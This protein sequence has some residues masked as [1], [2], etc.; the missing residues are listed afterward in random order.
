M[1]RRV[2]ILMVAVFA[3]F[4][5]AKKS[6]AWQETHRLSLSWA[7][8]LVGE[9]NDMCLGSNSLYVAED[10][11][12]FSIINLTD[13]TRKWYTSLKAMDGSTTALIKIRKIAVVEP[14]NRL[15]INE[16]DGTDLIRIIDT[17]D[18]DTLKDTIPITGATADIKDMKFYNIPNPVDQ[19]TIEGMFSAGRT[20]RIGVYDGVANV[21]FG[22][23]QEINCSATA[24]GFDVN[25]THIFVAVEQRG[26]AIYNRTTA[27][28]VGTVDLP[29]EAQRVKV[30]GNFAYVACR[31]SGL[32]IVDISNPAAPV[33]VTGYDTSGYASNLDIR[34]HYLALSS[35]GGGVYLF[36]ITS[37]LNPVLIDHLTSCGYANLVKFHQN[38]LMV[39]SR[40]YGILIYNFQ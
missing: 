4:G 39:A 33:R 12:G 9:P 34:D 13:Y 30:V 28:L 2:I 16:T 40:D 6:T 22:I 11:G 36:D 8:P 32:W 27:A 18:P 37:P 1:T 5:C 15:F 26:L 29:G 14:R 20:L 21:W 3:L 38:K 25:A 19:F 31:Q 23:T 35:G 17:S 7:V 10:Q 24:N